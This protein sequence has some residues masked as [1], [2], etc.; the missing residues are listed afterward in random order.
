[1]HYEIYLDVV[2]L[3][4]LM[5]E[6]VVLRLTGSIVRRKS[7]LFRCFLAAFTG[8]TLL[9]VMLVLHSA[10]MIRS[11]LTVM[12][13]CDFL[14]TVIAFY[15]KKEKI[16][17]IL[18]MMV[19]SYIVSFLIGGILNAVYGYTVVG[20][21]WNTLGSAVENKAVS[22]YFVCL[23]ALI[24]FILGKTVLFLLKKMKDTK[25][26]YWEV[27][28]CMGD[29][30]K[31]VTALADT[32]NHLVEPISGKPVHVVEIG[33]ISDIMKAE[34]TDAVKNFYDKNIMDR[35][36]YQ[37]NGIRMIPFRAV[38]TPNEKLLVGISIDRM[39]FK[40]HTIDY[41]T[42]KPYVALYDGVLAHDG[43][44]HMLLHGGEMMRRS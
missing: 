12:A 13:V 40:N 35:G 23:G 21:Y 7:T 5:F 2:F 29:S 9:C 11:P 30:E 6:F 16:Y 26:I 38:G 19:V 3:I 8:S 39:K 31:K 41:E 1:M 27:T 14:M 32:G 4:N 34:F 18:G 43:S 44:Y 24:C 20:Y 28:L 10:G 25:S 37:G 15:R 33:V 22:W 36:L 42:E 17:K